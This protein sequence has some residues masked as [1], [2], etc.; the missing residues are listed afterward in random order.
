M[1]RGSVWTRRYERATIRLDCA[2][3]EPTIQTIGEPGASC[4]RTAKTKGQRTVGG[5]ITAPHRC[6]HGHDARVTCH[7]VDLNYA[8]SKNYSLRSF[9]EL[10][11][12]VSH[13]QLRADLHSC[14]AAVQKIEA[15][16]P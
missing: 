11:T 4:I 12:H 10:F 3:L 8:Q 1:W 7:P 14:A 15:A 13:D 9:H 6:G 16:A 2:T 5:F